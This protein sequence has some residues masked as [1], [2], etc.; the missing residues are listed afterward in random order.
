M[1][2][3]RRAGRTVHR[4]PQ[5]KPYK[6]LTPLRPRFAVRCQTDLERRVD[7]LLKRK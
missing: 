1:K 7:K 4:G 6:A 3:D 2:L 5:P